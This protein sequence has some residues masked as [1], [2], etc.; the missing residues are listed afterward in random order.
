MST[1]APSNPPLSDEQK[2]LILSYAAEVR[3]FEIE[4]FWQR[5]LFFWGFIGAAMVAYA[6]L[7]RDSLAQLLI[8]CFGLLS[9][10]AWTLANRAGK[11]WHESWEQ[12]VE[13]YQCE[14]LGTDLFSRKESLRSKGVLG[15]ARYSAS[16]LTIAMSDLSLA[17]WALLVIRA[18]QIDPRAAISWPAAAIVGFTI[19][20]A[21]HIVRHAR[22]SN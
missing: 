13:R 10:L 1:P 20:Y 2:K 7:G 21:I 16:K 4:R 6:T 14:V 18:L 15:A 11:Y 3:R 8:G 9:S 12:K 5:S 19:L 22:S 17:L